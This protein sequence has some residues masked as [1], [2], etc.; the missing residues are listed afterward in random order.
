ME[1]P[2]NNNKVILKTAILRNT[3][4]KIGFSF[5]SN[6]WV[7]LE[8]AAAPKMKTNLRRIADGSRWVFKK[9]PRFISWDSKF[10]VWTGSRKVL[11]ARREQWFTHSFL[12]PSKKAPRDLNEDYS[13]Q[14]GI[15]VTFWAGLQHDSGISRVFCQR[16]HF[17]EDG[18]RKVTKDWRDVSCRGN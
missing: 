9:N 11:K 15:F 6:W 2:N 14:F 12:T 13:Q 5:W 4:S 7:T 8:F 16:C 10:V 3:Q 18:D 17:F 1:I